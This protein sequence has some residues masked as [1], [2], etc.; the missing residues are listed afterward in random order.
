MSLLE[1]SSAQLAKTKAFLGE[2]FALFSNGVETLRRDGNAAK[3]PK[4]G[5]P[6]PAFTL[7]D[8]NGNPV[9]LAG[10]LAK[11]PVVITFYRGEWCPYCNLAVH[12]FQEVMP[13]L[14][15][16]GAALV[17]ITPEKADFSQVMTEKHE[18]TFPVLTDAG[19]KVSDAYGLTFTIDDDIKSFV[20]ATFKSDIGAR[21]A[22]GSWQVP[23]PGTF[24]IDKAGVIRFA[25]VDPDYMIGRA[26][27]ADVLRAL[28]AL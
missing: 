20:G 9:S 7:P 16:L 13:Q 3:A 19:S 22:D 26:E 21:N 27:P 14:E 6:A 18:L 24:V 17:A 5:Q 2:K 8:A 1:S 10:L 12:A 15:A 11:G 25:H 28:E 23:I 4:V